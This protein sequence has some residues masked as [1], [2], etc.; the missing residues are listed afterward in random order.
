V[1]AAWAAAALLDALRAE[2]AGVLG[3]EHASRQHALEA[4]AAKLAT[5]AAAFHAADGEAAGGEGIE[6]YCATCGAWIGIFRNLP[7]WRHFYG[8]PRPRRAA[9]PVRAGH[10]AVPAWCIPPGRALSPAQART[11]GEALADA[12]TYRLSRARG[13][14]A[15]CASDPAGAWPRH[16]S[17]TTP[18]LAAGKDPG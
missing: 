4:A 10:E 8:D 3:D 5:V 1:T 13:R 2:V 11:L 16:A 9:G 15:D 18:P 17:A 12:I 6:P 14:F 7:G